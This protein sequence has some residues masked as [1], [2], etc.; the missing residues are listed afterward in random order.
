MKILLLNG[1]QTIDITDIVTKITWSG[2]AKQAARKL[3]IG[4]AV[5]PTDRFLPRPFIDLGNMLKL[6]TDDDKELFQGYVFT[7]EKS[8]NGAEMDVTAYDGGI[9]LLKSKL[10]HN[11]QRMYPAQITRKCCQEVNVPIG[12][13]ANPGVYV[14]FVADGKTLYDII[15][16]AYTHSSKIEGSKY[17]PLM[18]NGKLDVI[19]KGQEIARYTL[20]AEVERESTLISDSTFSASI[21]NMVNRVKIYDDKK[22]QIGMAQNLN[23]IRSYG[24]I[25]DTYTKEQDKNPNTVAK[26]MLQGVEHKASVE[27]IGDIQCITGKAVKVKEPFT[28]LSGIF[29]ID[30]DTHTWDSGHHTMSLEL[31]FKNM[32]DEKE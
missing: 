27:A 2:N 9:Y 19:R 25:Q 6:L 16:T 18:R 22:N 30:N 26:N 14:S 28:G 11:F 13:L 10:T 24:V 4:V 32:M 8:S 12:N 29:Y 17:M 20:S 21:E 15:M 23:W 1:K 5:S 31:N 7:K 3:E